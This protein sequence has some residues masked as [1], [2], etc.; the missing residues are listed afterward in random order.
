VQELG[1]SLCEVK[2]LLVLRSGSAEACS[3]V[4]RMLE[5]KLIKVRHHIHELHKL[6]EELKNAMHACDKAQAANRDNRQPCPVLT[7]RPLNTRGMP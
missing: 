2:E 1:F 4:R 7:H 3:K 6:E 5:Q